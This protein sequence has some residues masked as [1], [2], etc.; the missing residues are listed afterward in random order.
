MRSSWAFPESTL[1][2]YPVRFAHARP[3][4]PV[5]LRMFRQHVGTDVFLSMSGIDAL[6]RLYGEIYNELIDPLPIERRPMR[7]S[8]S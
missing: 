8:P 1:K 5:V 3:F 4:L 7:R 2:Y 6:T